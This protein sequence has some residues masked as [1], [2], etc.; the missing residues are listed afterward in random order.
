M[1]AAG[2]LMWAI[3]WVLW[4][5]SGHGAGALLKGPFVIAS[6]VVQFG[7][8]LEFAT[9]AIL[10]FIDSPRARTLLWISSIALLLQMPLV[11]LAIYE[12]AGGAP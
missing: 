3:C 11:L 4:V 2:L 1:F 6:T 9:T 7:V 8:A 12:L 5:T 10:Y